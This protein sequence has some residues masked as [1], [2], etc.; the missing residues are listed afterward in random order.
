MRIAAP[1]GVWFQEQEASVEHQ[2]DLLLV[3]GVRLLHD[4]R[5]GI[6]WEFDID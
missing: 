6:T 1:V 2:V 5:V 3:S 4:W